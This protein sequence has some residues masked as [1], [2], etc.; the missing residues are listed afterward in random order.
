VQQALR[1]L[2]PRFTELVLM[3]DVCLCEYTSHATAA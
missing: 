2:R 1:A 3:T